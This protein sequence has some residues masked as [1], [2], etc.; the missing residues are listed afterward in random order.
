VEAFNAGSE[1]TCEGLDEN[2]YLPINQTDTE[3]AM[4][5]TRL[6]PYDRING[7]NRVSCTCTSPA[8]NLDTEALT[9]SIAHFSFGTI[10]DSCE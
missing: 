10:V 6:L 9:L 3:T 1:T 5:E 2:S 4:K 7:Q 8:H